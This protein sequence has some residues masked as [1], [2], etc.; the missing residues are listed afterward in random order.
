MTRDDFRITKPEI[1]FWL[2]IIGIIVSGV[3]AFTT[4]KSQVQAMQDK[5]IRLRTEYENSLGKIE[6]A[7]TELQK[8]S[9]D[10]KIDIAEIKQ[11]IIY[12]KKQVQ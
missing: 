1:Q 2:A 6:T 9:N 3:I 7:L 4:L 10:L 11:D 5:G 8:C 12:I